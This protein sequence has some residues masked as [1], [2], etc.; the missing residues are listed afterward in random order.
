MIGLDCDVE[1]LS[2][3]S[4]SHIELVL[5]RLHHVVG[6]V[7]DLVVKLCVGNVDTLIH[8]ELIEVGAVGRIQSS[9]AIIFGVGIVVGNAFAASIVVG[10]LDAAGDFLR[11]TT[12]AAV[13]VGSAVVV[14]E[15]VFFV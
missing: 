9:A 12:V 1:P 3:L 5:R 14:L 10:A 6:T 11:T 7:V 2:G 8:A 13:V 15:E 4:P